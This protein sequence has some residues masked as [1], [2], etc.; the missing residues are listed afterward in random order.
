MEELREMGKQN[1]QLRPRAHVFLALMR[2]FAEEGNAA[3]VES[4]RDRLLPEAAGFVWP[5]ERAEADEL[6]IEAAVAAGKV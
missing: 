4:L 3:M 6:L 5:E 1:P 2:A